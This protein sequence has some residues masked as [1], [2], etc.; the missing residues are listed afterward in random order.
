MGRITKVMIAA[1]VVWG[2]S[3][4]ALADEPV[5]AQ[6]Q[7]GVIQDTIPAGQVGQPSVAEQAV[8]QA[9]MVQAAILAMV[10][11]RSSRVDVIILMPPPKPASNPGLDPLSP[12]L[13]PPIGPGWRNPPPGPK[14]PPKIQIFPPGPFGP[15]DPTERPPSKY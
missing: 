9:G 2:M 8:A 13:F 14:Y 10:A 7:N 15:P 6:D 1:A 3:G 4:I 11:D 12:R 5:P